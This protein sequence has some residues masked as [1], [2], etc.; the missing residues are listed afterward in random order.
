M[1][2][3]STFSISDISR[4]TGVN[5][6]TLR[7][8]ERRYGL[9]R[10]G[11]S[12]RGYRQYSHDDLVRI[13]RIRHWLDQGVAISQVGALLHGAAARAGG[14]PWQDC[15]EASLEALERGNSR[16]L[17]HQLAEMMSLYPLAAVLANWFDP[18]REQLR[19]SG[20]GSPR[21][22]QAVLLDTLVQARLSGRLLKQAPGRRGGGVLIAPLPG[23]DAVLAML[24]AL[25]IA[26]R[27]SVQWLAAPVSART[28]LQLAMAAGSAALLLC[29]SPSET[30]TGLSRSMAG[31][32]PAGA[33]PLFACCPEGGR[34][35]ALPRSIQPLRGD[36]QGV[37]NE[38]SGELS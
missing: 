15:R 9:L 1:T 36:R 32:V 2:A 10:P 4:E 14:G 12:E 28:A 26:E 25:V 3:Q 19:L 18:L 20:E 21:Q 27:N 16:R 17:E 29:L 24:Q 6:V 22:G 34:L 13:Q 7:A 8:W 37:L 33:P 31:R 30:R 11:R 5:A 38:L 23:A 35:P